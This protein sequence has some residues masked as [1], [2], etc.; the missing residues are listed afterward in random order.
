M[1]VD[2][3]TNDNAA[4]PDAPEI[5]KIVS[6]SHPV[7]G[8]VII[9]GG[10]TG[11]SY[12]PGT[13]YFGSDTF[14]Y[15]ISDGVFTSTASVLVKVPKDTYKPVATAPLQTFTA[16]T[17]GTSTVRARLTWTGTDKGYGI[18]K[19]ELWRSIN[20]HSYTK[21]VT[22]TGHQAYMTLNVGTSYRFRV[23]AI[24][25]KA[26]VGAFAYGP[27][28]TVYR[29]QENSSSAAYSSPWTNLNSS[30]YS[31]GHARGTSTAGFDVT[32]TTLGRTL[33]FVTDV[34][35]SRGTADV[36][37]DGVLTAHL[38]LTQSITKYRYLAYSITFAS[39]AVHSM[40]IVYTGGPTK[41]V[42]ADAFIFLR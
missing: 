2:L 12:R 7:H 36:Y 32:F 25:K 27:K 33:A 20:G 3:L 5:I 30:A 16:Q 14:T 1:P 4:N 19:F 26:N 31:G 18:S 35:P 22:T 21:V 17:I 38:T 24:D 39:S 11:L 9:T 42:D 28:F 40:R 6:A 23:R 41:R 13:N 15:T 37:I 10:G 29:Y 8:T 34:A